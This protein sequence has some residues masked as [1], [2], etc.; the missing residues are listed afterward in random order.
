M[1]NEPWRTLTLPGLLGTCARARGERPALADA[2]D[3]ASWTYGAPEKL[4][5]A[6]YGARVQRMA[7]VLKALKLREGERVLLAMPNTVDMPIALL[8]VM[9][10]GGIPAI[11]SVAMGA[12]AMAAAAEAVEA[13]MIIT[14]SQLASQTPMESAAKAAANYLPIRH[15][16]AFGADVTPG[17]V[18]LDQAMAF[19]GDAAKSARDYAASDA[20]LMTFQTT[21]DGLLPVVHSHAQVIAIALALLARTPLFS[22]GALISTVLPATAGAIAAAVVAPLLAGAAL[23][24]H[25]PFDADTL[26]EQVARLENAPVLLPGLTEGIVRGPLLHPEHPVILTYD[27]ERPVQHSKELPGATALLSLGER[28]TA[29]LSANSADWSAQP[30]RLLHPMPGVLPADQAWVKTVETDIGVCINGLGVSKMWGQGSLATPAML[31]WPVD[32]RP[33]RIVEDITVT[34]SKAA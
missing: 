23:H 7:A 32:A 24:L 34:S 26:V 20:A 10:A 31:Q 8:A 28:A 2:P 16:C 13:S 21:R 33:G 25:G 14:C 17:I 30:Q 5:F 15:V 3:R 1:L 4:S 12:P 22:A 29:V 19:A 6:E 18:P 11:A 27:V 9:E